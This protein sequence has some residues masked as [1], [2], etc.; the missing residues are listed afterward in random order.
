MADKLVAEKP[1]IGNN[2]TAF[3]SVVKICGDSGTNWTLNCILSATVQDEGDHYMMDAF[4][5]LAMPEWAVGD[6]SAL[7]WTWRG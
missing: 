1:A 5:K 3:Q 6:V 2:Y 7:T 4:W